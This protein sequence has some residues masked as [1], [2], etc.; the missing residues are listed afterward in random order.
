MYLV[1]NIMIGELGDVAVAS[2]GAAS[3]VVFILMVFLFGINSGGSIFVAQFFGNQDVRSIRKINIIMLISGALVSLVFTVAFLTIPSTVMMIFSKE[4]D[5]LRVGA[6]Y[7]YYE[8]FGILPVAFSFTIIFCLRGIGDV[9]KVSIISGVCTIL[10]VIIGYILMFGYLEIES[11][12]V[13]GV[14]IGFSISRWI[15]LLILI[16]V[17]LKRKEFIPRRQDFNEISFPYISNFYKRI[18]PVVLNE[19]MWVAGMTAFTV[20]YGRMGTE[21]M[22]ASNIFLTIEKIGIVLFWG[23]AQACAIIV[24]NLI[25]AKEYER[26]YK[27]AGRILWICF[28]ISCLVSVIIFFTRMNI[29]ELFNVSDKVRLN[30]LIIINIFVILL[31][32]KA[33]NV[34][35]LVGVIRSG[36]DT[37]YSLILELIVLWML[38]VPGTFFNAFVMEV[39]LA[40]VYITQSSEEVIKFFV[41]VRRYKSKKWIND[42]T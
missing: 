23:L 30:V 1:S 15:E 16:S 21:V 6:E 11:M 41:G 25:G 27:D 34:V 22:A 33:I 42:L 2:V 7:L 28:V 13:K 31:P 5:V 35:N 26:A 24:G 39:S 40:L 37:K 9:K 29:V 10:G 20:V 14:A 17:I 36:G 12:G 18:I 38:A 3:Q 19:L 4:A 8:A 32:I